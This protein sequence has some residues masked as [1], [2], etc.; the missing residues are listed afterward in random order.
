MDESK[1]LTLAESLKNLIPVGDVVVRHR[2][3]ATVAIVKAVV[4][5]VGVLRFFEHRLKA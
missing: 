2:N 3:V 1:V 5:A 4:K